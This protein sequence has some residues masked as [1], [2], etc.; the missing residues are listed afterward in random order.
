MGAHV[1]PLRLVVH[2]S[3][4]DRYDQ[5]KVCGAERGSPCLD[6]RS[7]RFPHLRVQPHT[8]RDLENTYKGPIT[9]PRLPKG[10]I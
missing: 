4:W 7:A 9:W 3:P 6:M 5:C 2:P 10:E 1:K 8:A